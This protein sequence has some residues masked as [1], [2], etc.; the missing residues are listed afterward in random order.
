MSPAVE[1]QVRH[2]DVCAG[3][4]IDMTNRAITPVGGPV[5][6]GHFDIVPGHI[7]AA[8]FMYEKVKCPTD[9]RASRS[10]NGPCPRTAGVPS[11]IHAN[12]DRR[13]TG[14]APRPNNREHRVRP[15]DP[16]LED[17]LVSGL[18]SRLGAVRGAALHARHVLPGRG[19]RSSIGRVAA[20]SVVN[21]V[22]GCR[23]GNRKGQN[24]SRNQRKNAPTVTEAT[25]D[26]LLPI[27][28]IHLETST[29]NLGLP[30]TEVHVQNTSRTRCDRPFGQCCEIH[31]PLLAY[32]QRCSRP[33]KAYRAQPSS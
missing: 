2:R 3:P 14:A 11:L 15:S 23:C 16:T 30:N 5:K 31:H 22:G 10:E 24:T 19:C 13:A 33:A 28:G 9:R 18:G 17:D 12:V 29:E 8:G 7:T 26:V 32:V 1:I 25:H 20:R 27:G 21:V 6:P 4:E